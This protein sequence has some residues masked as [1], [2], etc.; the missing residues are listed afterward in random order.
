MKV[1]VFK[2]ALNLDRMLP[3]YSLLGIWVL[4]LL[5]M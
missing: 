3:Y 1:S 2:E 4:H 5:V